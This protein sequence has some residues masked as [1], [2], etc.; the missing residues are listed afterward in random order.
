MVHL[1]DSLEPNP[2]LHRLT[3]GRTVLQVVGV[4]W[5]LSRAGAKVQGCSGGICNLP[6][7]DNYDDLETCVMMI[8]HGSSYRDLVLL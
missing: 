1:G 6:G 7:S 3:V 2:I 5:G 4:G 8:L